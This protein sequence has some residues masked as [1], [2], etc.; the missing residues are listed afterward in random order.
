MVQVQR[1]GPEAAAQVY[2]VV[3]AAFGARPALDPPADA[4]GESVSSI[5]E[6][7]TGHGGLLAVLD[8]EP[9]GALILDRVG[10][11]AFIRR[12]GVVPWAQGRGVAGALAASAL[13]SVSATD[14]EEVA[15]VARDELP[16]SIGFWRAQGFAPADH[17]PPYLT[18][19]RPLPLRFDAATGAE[20]TRL[21][22]RVGRGLQAGDVVVL[23][24]ELGAGK[25]TLTQ[26]IG[27]GL[28]VRGQVT[29]PTFVISRVHPSLDGGPPLI[30]V[31]AYRLGGVAELD[32]LDLDTSLEEG[33]TVVEWGEGLA[34]G[35]SDS[36]L[37]VRITR[38]VGATPE[39]VEDDAA[40]PRSV[41][42]RAFG[43]RWRP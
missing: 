19:T 11:R 17:T 20:M 6:A 35:L 12:F 16:A 14:A 9:V 18:M 23:I 33:V 43:P 40:D 36:R 10:S 2:A 1:I 41:E 37:E 21:G 30:H 4:D 25:T 31:D 28:A 5:A 22:E 39:A 32:D 42:L 24:G 26:G 15:I 7:L 13:L 34:E 29:S 27:A 3:H 8:D 38:T